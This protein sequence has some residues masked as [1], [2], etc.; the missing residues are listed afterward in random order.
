MLLTSHIF[1]GLYLISKFPPYIAL[2]AALISHFL[3]D[4]F[5]PHWNPH[6][7]SEMKKSGKISLF[8]LKIIILD[9]LVS[10]FSVV[11]FCYHAYPNLEK[12][13]LILI[14]AFLSILPDICEIPY[15]F[16]KSKSKLLQKF[17]NFE[18]QNQAK[19]N[20]FWGT[21]SQIALILVCI[22]GLLA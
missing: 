20:A 6:L 12:I 15:Y 19:A 10:F 17:I 3:F 18:H 1:L 5:Y 9:S 13:L 7:F 16:L 14:S 11:W 8:S 21:V 22:W 2:P 4:Y